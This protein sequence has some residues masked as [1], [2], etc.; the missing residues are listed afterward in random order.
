MPHD[1]NAHTTPDREPADP[2]PQRDDLAHTLVAE[3]ERS[4]CREETRGEEQI[5][6][7]PRDGERANQGLAVAL[8]PRLRD[9]MPFDGTGSD[10]GE[11]SHGAESSRTTPASQTISL[12]ARLR[13]AQP[14][15]YASAATSQSRNAVMRGSSRPSGRHT[16]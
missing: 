4:A 8:E 13:A 10:A 1:L 15:R 5:D 16:R 11:L 3:R 2:V 14:I 12:H 9:V 6:V 7:A